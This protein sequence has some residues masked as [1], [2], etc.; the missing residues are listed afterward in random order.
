MPRI[1][2]G[3]QQVTESAA[4]RDRLATVKIQGNPRERG[5][6]DGRGRGGGGGGGAVFAA[7]LGR[8]P[9]ENRAPLSAIP[10]GDEKGRGG[11]GIKRVIE[12]DRKFY[13]GS[14]WVRVYLMGTERSDIS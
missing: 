6:M 1:D 10:R 7:M 2:G 4:A 5:R 12:R 11:K 9:R 14:K 13:V 8:E 3:D